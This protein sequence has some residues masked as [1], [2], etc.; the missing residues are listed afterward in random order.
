[1]R[2]MLIFISMEGLKNDRRIFIDSNYFIAL[3]NPVDTLHEKARLVGEKISTQ[4]LSL[5]ISNFILLE[6]LTVVSQKV[7]RYAAV[8]AGNRLRENPLIE[9]IHIDE[10]LQ[11]DSWNIFQEI[12]KK[13]ISFVDCSIIA[14]MKAERIDALLTFDIKDFEPLLKQ[15]KFHFYEYK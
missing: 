7:G 3:L 2:V 8:Q 14:V 1:M 5:V 13:D 6:I 12:V 11:E 9:V 10:M 15:Y 4:D